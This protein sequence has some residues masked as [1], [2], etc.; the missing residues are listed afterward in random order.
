LRASRRGA[1]ALA[2]QP[3][4]ARRR[5][6]GFAASGFY[7]GKE[8]TSPIVCNMKEFKVKAALY[9]A[10]LSTG[11]FST[12]A[13]GGEH[14]APTPRQSGRRRVEIAIST[15]WSGKVAVM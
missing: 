9:R 8:R 6:C 4:G 10:A 13:A 12:Q 2:A 11:C 3:K 1:D 7:D 5:T 15:D 14:P